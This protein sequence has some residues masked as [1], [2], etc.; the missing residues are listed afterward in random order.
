MAP[1]YSRIEFYGGDAFLRDDLFAILDRVPPT[2]KITLWSTCSQVPKNRAFAERLQTYRIEAI[3]VHL[4]LTFI[5]DIARPGPACS[6]GEIFRKVNS[7]SAW[8]VPIHLYVPMDRMVEFNAAFANNIHQLGVERLYAF[9]RELGHPLVNSV[10]CFGRELG[11][12]RLLWV[13]KEKPAF[14]PDAISGG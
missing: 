12:V 2:K 10:A 1:E 11:R 5:D 7:V 9:T 3:K 13:K 6:L 4:P 14:Y 8:G